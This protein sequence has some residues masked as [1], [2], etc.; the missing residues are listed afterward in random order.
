MF[1]N[2]SLAQPQHNKIFK[3]LSIPAFFNMPPY[4]GSRPPRPQLSISPY[5]L[6]SGF[7]GPNKAGPLTP[8]LPQP[9]AIL[10][11]DAYGNQ[12]PIT[13]RTV[14]AMRVHAAHSFSD[15]QPSA[16]A[17]VGEEED[18]GFLLESAQTHRHSSLDATVLRE[19][20]RRRKMGHHVGGYHAGKNAR[21]G[22]SIRGIGTFYGASRLFGLPVSKLVSANGIIQE[23][24]EKTAYG[25]WAEAIAERI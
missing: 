6:M 12:I 16:D 7:P 13:Q 1:L 9:P 24:Q 22:P 5:G 14:S 25:A 18:L 15:E 21:Q 23:M 10:F 4:Y 3:Q 20:R 8:V 2:A 17:E 19:Q 11:V